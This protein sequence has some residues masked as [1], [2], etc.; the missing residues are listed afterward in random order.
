MNIFT[1]KLVI[2]LMLFVNII[3]Y[4]Q[5]KVS[6]NGIEYPIQTISEGKQH[7]FKV[8]EVIEDSRC[9]KDVTCVWEGR[10]IVKLGAFINDKKIDERQVNLNLVTSSDL[11][12]INKFLDTSNTKYVYKLV[13]ASSQ[14]LDSNK[15]EVENYKVNIIVQEI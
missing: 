6:I 15:L 4:A 1:S 8:I 7:P 10:L 11:E 12:W 2:T 5:N 14:R 13:N 3:A 9:P